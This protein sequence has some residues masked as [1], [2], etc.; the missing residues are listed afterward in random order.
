MYLPDK[1][2]LIH[3]LDDQTQTLLQTYRVELER[4][5][6]SG[7]RLALHLSSSDSL[8]RTP[9]E[10]LLVS[11]RLPLCLLP[12][13][14]PSLHPVHFSSKPSLSLKFEILFEAREDL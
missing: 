6:G 14:K 12:L 11:Q 5:A 13:Q 9:Q 8:L 7:M 3:P 4:K 2:W 1:E 10:T